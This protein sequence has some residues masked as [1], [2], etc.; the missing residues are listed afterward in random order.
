MEII[1][2]R[3]PNKWGSGPEVRSNL[4]KHNNTL[5]FGK[6]RYGIYFIDL[7]ALEP[8]L[9]VDQTDLMPE[10]PLS[11]NPSDGF[12][13]IETE[14][15]IPHARLKLFSLSRSSIHSTDLLNFKE[16]DL[17]LYHL[18]RSVHSKNHN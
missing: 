17:D 7:L 5:Y 3:L 2:A 18:K 12:I 8:F 4:F 9:H 15:I 16:T 1:S 6:A 10:I 14:K 13:T 11:P